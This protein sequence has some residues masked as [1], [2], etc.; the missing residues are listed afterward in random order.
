MK[1]AIL[2]VAFGT[3]MQEARKALDN[4]DAK[5]REAFPGEEIRWAYTS[6]FIRAKLAQEGNPPDSPEMAIVRLLDERFTH[7]A[8][9]SLHVMPGEE[10]HRLH[11]NAQLFAKMIG[12]FQQIVIAP[13]L[14]SSYTDMTR[15]AEAM[16]KHIPSDR[17]PDEAVIF[18][19]HGNK[20]HPADAMYAAMNYVMQ[21]LDRNVHMGTVSGRPELNDILPRLHGAGSRKVHLMPFMT[22]AGEHVRSDMAGNGPDSWKSLL[23]LN[24]FTCTALFN[25]IAEYPEI[26]D[27]WLGHLRTALTRL[28]GD[29]G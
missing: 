23:E 14:L 18:M 28:G 8:I 19:G 4:I 7:L 25:G 20:K 3:R 9:L 5:A 11:H 26:V 21:E 15:V 24:G 1:K 2:L 13:P 10:F 6:R 27:V 22:V 16:L 12:G 29:A 17:K